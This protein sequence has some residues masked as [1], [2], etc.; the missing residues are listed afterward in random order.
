MLYFSECVAEAQNTAGVVSECPAEAQNTAGVDSKRPA[1]A[2]TRR[3]QSKQLAKPVWK[4]RDTFPKSPSAP[5]K[6]KTLQA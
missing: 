6:P 1:E 5:R 2:Q 4:L 3:E